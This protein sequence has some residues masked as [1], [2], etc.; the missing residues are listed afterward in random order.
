MNPER[1]S[2]R[3]LGVKGSFPTLLPVFHVSF[4]K[5][6]IHDDDIVNVGWTLDTGVTGDGNRQRGAWMGIWGRNRQKPSA[7]DK[8]IIQAV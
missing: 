2:H 8:R 6:R 3:A 1:D 5:L 7:A 4:I